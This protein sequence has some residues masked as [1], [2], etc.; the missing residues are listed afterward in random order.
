[1]S[2]RMLANLDSV[3]NLAFSKAYLSI[4]LCVVKFAPN[5]CKA[6]S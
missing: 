4:A 1:M 6:C 5:P 2:P 3:K